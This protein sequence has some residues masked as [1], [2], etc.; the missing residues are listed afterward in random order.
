MCQYFWNWVFFFIYLVCSIHL[1]FTHWNPVFSVFF[2][3]LLL[4]WWWIVRSNATRKVPTSNRKMRRKKKTLKKSNESQTKSNQWWKK[5]KCKLI[6]LYRLIF[7]T[8]N[9]T[10]ELEK[11]WRERWREKLLRIKILNK[12][13]VIIVIIVLMLCATLD[14]DTIK[15]Q[16]IA[17]H[18]GI[19][20]V[21]LKQN[22]T[23]N[24]KKMQPQESEQEIA[25]Q[26]EKKNNQMF[27]NQS[28]RKR[29]RM[30]TAANCTWVICNE[31]LLGDHNR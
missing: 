8:A 16:L 6:Y 17:I 25:I 4:F 13:K 10:I 15:S 20:F 26:E 2:L 5:T 19:H 1:L 12:L 31:R 30:P 27:F 28:E 3:L 14:V 21:P 7:Q 9:E 23:I 24:N 29:P 18:R 11:K 22:Q